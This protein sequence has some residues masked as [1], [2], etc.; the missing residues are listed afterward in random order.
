MKK[1]YGSEGWF[2]EKFLAEHIS[3]K[4]ALK[5]SITSSLETLLVI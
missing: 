4:D 1:K 3:V 2:Q 5:L